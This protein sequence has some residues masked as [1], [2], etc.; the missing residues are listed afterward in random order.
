MNFNPG[1]QLQ[2]ECSVLIDLTMDSK[3]T[4][5]RRKRTSARETGTDTSSPAAP[6]SVTNEDEWGKHSISSRSETSLDSD[7][8]FEGE[9]DEFGDLKPRVQ[10]EQPDDTLL[11]VSGFIGF[12]F[13]MICAALLPVL[14]I[15]QQHVMAGAQICW[16][17]HEVDILSGL[18]VVSSR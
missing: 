15:D 12:V 2:H 9:R 14:G 11:F 5:R 3:Q 13:C 4:I 7:D 10:F 6:T 16:Y 17:L 18:Q 8:E 1:C